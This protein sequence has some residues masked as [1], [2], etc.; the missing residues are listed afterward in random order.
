MMINKDPRFARGY[1]YQQ[2]LSMKEIQ[3]IRASLS[4]KEKASL[5]SG[6]DFW[7]LKSIVEKNVPDI[8]V[9]DGPHGLRKQIESSADHMG[10]GGSVSATCFP[11]ASAMASSWDAELLN[12]VGRALGEECRQEQVAVL[13]GPGVN[14]KR[15][16]LC[17][18]NF[19]Y[20]SEDPYLGGK[21]AASLIR[22][23][24]SLGVGTSLKH[25][26]ANNQERRRM[27]IDAVV[28]ER[29][30]RE[31]YLAGFETAVKEAQPKTVMCAYNKL[32]GAFCSENPWLLSRILKEE[33]GFEG[34]VVTDWGAVNN[35]VAGLKSG[36]DLEMPASGGYNDNL[37]V[38]AVQSGALQEET[39]DAAVDRILK[40]ILD[41]H[42]V[43]QEEFTYNASSHH[44]L[45]RRTEAESAVLLKND[46][47]LPLDGEQFK[48][49]SSSGSSAK[50]RPKLALIGTFAK[51]PRYQGS[52]SSLINP[53]QLDNAYDAIARELGGDQQLLYA[54]GYD[55]ANEEPDSRLIKEAVDAAAAADTV[56]VFAGL[57]EISESEGFDR[58]HL[59]MPRSHNDLISAVAQVNPQ[60]AVVLSNG[61]PVL[62]PWL[63]ST[64]AVL[65][66]YLGGQAWGSAVSDIIFGRVN[67]SG[68]LAE[69]FPQSLEAV[70][71][72]AQ[73]P[74]GGASVIYTDSI[75]V[76]YRYF[77]TTGKRV[78]FPFGHGLS[79]TQFS[80]GGMSISGVGTERK[81]ECRISNNGSRAGKEVMQLYVHPEQSSVFRPEQELKGFAKVALDPGEE[82][83]VEFRLNHR[84][85][86]YWDPGA[87]DWLVE[88]GNFEIRVG[89]SSEEIRLRD[90]IQID[91]AQ[92]PSNKAADFK[93]VVPEYFSPSPGLFSDISAESPFRKL[94]GRPIPPSDPDPT[95][96]FT[97]NSTLEETTRTFIGRILFKIAMR[98]GERMMSK[99]S[100]EKSIAMMQAVIREMPLKNLGMMGGDKITMHTVD[101]L[102]LML[103]G[104]F[105]RGL[106]GLL[107][108]K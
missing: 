58:E 50:E 105:L 96:G 3:E 53:S 6:K 10:I 92:P 36:L 94:L 39:L 97:R 29:A 45:A 48:P 69:T 107:R 17:G 31:L 30:L 100:D 20:F 57:P 103:N 42:G 41:T 85:F 95:A 66:S 54:A 5:C 63:D 61:A 52:G 16:P 56:I 101:S 9:A 26:A 15:S 82:K 12:E 55:P 32:N 81:V 59:S 14:I 90:T 60:T 11:T 75:Y 76:G 28:D 93:D 27:I 25:F 2:R 19:E 106:A 47:L 89:A 108:G 73:F 4:L 72:S 1:L 84:S 8:M 102:I 23:V 87:G 71:S 22:G 34:F 77:S 80:Y 40:V 70:P 46:N 43:L 7:H 44:E 62:M 79:Y 13:L 24:Q 83:T 98:E 78:L 64:P 35:R 65:E 51:A 74:G 49:G 21:L 86:A 99:E 37:I 91:S 18:R 68:K 104:K 88:S 33:W 67:P 38:E